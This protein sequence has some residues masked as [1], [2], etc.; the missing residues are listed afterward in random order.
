MSK[1]FGGFFSFQGSHTSIKTTPQAER[2]FQ[3]PCCSSLGWPLYVFLYHF[4]CSFLQSGKPPKR[5]AS[6]LLQFVDRKMSGNQKNP[7]FLRDRNPWQLVYH[8]YHVLKD[9]FGSQTQFGSAERSGTR[10]QQVQ[11]PP[12]IH[13]CARMFSYAFKYQQ[14]EG[15]TILLRSQETFLHSPAFRWLFISWVCVPS[16]QSKSQH[17]PSRRSTNA[18]AP[19][20]GEG[21]A[22]PVPRNVTSIAILN[23]SIPEREIF[24]S[25]SRCIYTEKAPNVVLLREGA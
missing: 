21:Y 23:V 3:L 13:R 8:F 15:Q 25:P 1:P 5:A 14:H 6:P 4:R 24:K 2:L 18:D 19:L 10:A 16:P 22:E 17:S 20:V 7:Q 9:E 12:P 11:Q